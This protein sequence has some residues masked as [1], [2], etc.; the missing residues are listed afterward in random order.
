MTWAAFWAIFALVV[1]VNFIPRLREVAPRESARIPFS[2]AEPPLLTLDDHPVSG[3]PSYNDYRCYSR[4]VGSEYGSE[5]YGDP[6]L[7]VPSGLAR[8]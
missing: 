6:T 1:V 2:N 5:A 7:L 8:D 3:V 4:P